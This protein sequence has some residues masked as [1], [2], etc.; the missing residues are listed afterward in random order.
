M[1]PLDDD[2][3]ISR[4]LAVRL[5][6]QFDKFNLEYFGPP[7][8]VGGASDHSPPVPIERILHTSHGGLTSVSFFG[9][10]QSPVVSD[11]LY[12]IGGDFVTAI[13]CNETILVSIGSLK[14]TIRSDS[15]ITNIC[16]L[17]AELILVFTASGVGL[18]PTTGGPRLAQH[19]I[20][21]SRKTVNRVVPVSPTQVVA[22]TTDGAVYIISWAVGNI[23]SHQLMIAPNEVSLGVEICGLAFRNQESLLTIIGSVAIIILDLTIVDKPKLVYKKTIRS[24]LSEDDAVWIDDSRLVLPNRGL[25]LVRTGNGFDSTSI[26]NRSICKKL[27]D[28]IL[29][30]AGAPAA[31]H[32]SG[33]T[34]GQIEPTGSI[35]ALPGEHQLPGTD[36]MLLVPRQG[37]DG[38]LIFL[39]VAFRRSAE[40]VVD[41]YK[42]EVMKW[43]EYVFSLSHSEKYLEA[44]DL[45]IQ[46]RQGKLPLLADTLET[47]SDQSVIVGIVSK[48]LKNSSSDQI[49]MDRVVVL[50]SLFGLVEEVGD[51][52]ETN[53]FS[54]KK[55]DFYSCLIH[56]VINRILPT[57]SLTQET[58]TR[59][60]TA[61]T[62]SP[63]IDSFVAMVIVKGGKGGEVLVDTNKVVRIATANDWPESIVVIHTRLLHDHI[64]PLKYWL[65]TN[66]LDP[67]LAA[68]YLY[69]LSR[70][71]RFPCMDI[72]SGEYS[73]V[74]RALIHEEQ[75]TFESILSRDPNAVLDCIGWDLSEVL[76]NRFPVYAI[77]CAI[78]RNEKVNVQL[79][80]E[81]LI[82][83]SELSLILAILDKDNGSPVS[84]NELGLIFKQLVKA[85]SMTDSQIIKFSTK[86]NLPL[87]DCLSVCLAASRS[88]VA[89]KLLGTKGE[90]DRAITLIEQEESSFEKKLDLAT[91]LTSKSRKGDDSLIGLWASLLNDSHGGHLVTENVRAARALACS[92]DVFLLASR[93]NCIAHKAWLMEIFKSTNRILQQAVNVS[94]I[95]VGTQFRILANNSSVK[96]KGISV[97]ASICHSCLDP[98][99]TS[100]SSLMLF[101]CGHIVHNHCGDRTA[102]PV[103]N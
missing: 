85:D 62:N 83:Q 46:L 94:A 57:T 35:Q 68:Y 101:S 22:S 19:E 50:A 3:L 48:Y 17:S 60:I 47:L 16:L 30:L 44:I 45:L 39:V 74:I 98:I 76:G 40:L 67:D 15:I 77:K 75:S 61:C 52:F 87:E 90:M 18:Y 29:M 99:T 86:F 14:T 102:C 79:A 34:L 7:E 1:S 24:V 95:D 91:W 80:I 23:I 32:I 100:K 72:D 26:E 78:A 56:L 93:V 89:V 71:R 37:V 43:I 20:S 51:I 10:N 36:W 5:T 9:Q 58:V 13:A 54:L 11:A 82:K 84:A 42:S 38:R 21:E 55:N 63:T 70:C 65:T 25:C 66:R 96:S 6:A 2:N 103:C 31:D 28:N 53:S 41:I 27:S 64:F 97:T 8:G 92:V 4:S 59:A 33:I 49:R 12:T 81:T 88:E 69:C 73:G